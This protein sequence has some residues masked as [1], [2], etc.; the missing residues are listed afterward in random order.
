MQGV[1]GERDGDRGNE[2]LRPHRERDMITA[3]AFLVPLYYPTKET[4]VRA[5]TAK[6]IIFQ[7]K[8]SFNC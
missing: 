7:M 2:L 6:L 8:D 1:R 5:K 3:G 4:E